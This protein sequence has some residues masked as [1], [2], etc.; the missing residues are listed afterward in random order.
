MKATRTQLAMAILLGVSATAALAADVEVKDAWVRGTVTGQ[1]ATGAFLEITSKSGA[2]LV[3]AASP[4]AGVSEIHEMKMDGGI[5]KMRAVERLQLPAGKPVQL[6]PGGYHVMLLNLKQ[7]LKRGDSV[8][9]T[10]QVETPGKKVEAVQIKAEVRDL[11][12]TP[13]GEHQH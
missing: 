2:T 9:L 10:L 12:A 4:V 1:K 7:P 5:M 3:G 6:A 8:A 11:A 13:A